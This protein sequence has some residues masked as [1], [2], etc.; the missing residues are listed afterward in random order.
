MKYFVD[1]C[2][3]F[4]KIQE[5]LRIA[6]RGEPATLEK[7]KSLSEKWKDNPNSISKIDQH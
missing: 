2:V 3:P 4:M 7:S 6:H 1:F 5:I